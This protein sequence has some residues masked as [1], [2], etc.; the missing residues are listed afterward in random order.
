[1]C[2]PRGTQCRPPRGAAGGGDRPG[3]RKTLEQHNRPLPDKSAVRLSLQRVSEPRVGKNRLHLDLPTD[4]LAAGPQR[5]APG[6]VTGSRL[7][8]PGERLV[9]FAT[10]DVVR[11][12]L[13]AMTYCRTNSS[14]ASPPRWT[15]ASRS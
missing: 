3:P 7:T 11:E 1:M 10:G 14:P 13:I 12:R 2:P 8:E 4:D 15:A 9:T 5:F 6:Y